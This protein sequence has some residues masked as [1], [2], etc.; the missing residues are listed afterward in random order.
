MPSMDKLVA[1]PVT[2][3]L[4][5]GD[6]GSGKTGSIASLVKAGYKVRVLDMDNGWESLAAAVR[7]TCPDKLANVEVESFRDKFKTTNIGPVLDG[8]PSAF[9]NAMKLLDHWKVVD[10]DLGK[11]SEWG[12]DCILVVDSL[13]F[14]S[15][16]AYNWADFMN[17]GMKDKRQVYYSAQEVIEKALALLTGEGFKTNVIITAHIKF[18]DMPDG[19]KRG[20][21]TSVGSALSPT[22]PRY[23]NSVALCQTAPGGKRTIQTASTA[24][25]DLKNPAGFKMVNSLPIE[26]GLADFFKTLRS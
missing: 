4:L 10:K 25:M 5:I 22:I 18:V 15:D 14:L 20:Y 26:S 17:P 23:F 21:P 1:N 6:S 12:P 2:K 11:P 16:A 24:L 8:T 9:I 13:T 19:T 3:L 7:N